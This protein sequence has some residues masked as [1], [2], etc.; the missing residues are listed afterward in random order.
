[1]HKTRLFVLFMKKIKDGK[2]KF[3]MIADFSQ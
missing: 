2:K 3:K 1:M